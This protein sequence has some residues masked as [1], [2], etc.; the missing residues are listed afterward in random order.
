MTVKQ[1]T[2][3]TAENTDTYTSSSLARFA[4]RE[5]PFGDLGFLHVVFQSGERYVYIGVP[6]EE[7]EEL[8][9]RAYYPD[10]YT[11]SVGKFFYKNIRNKYQRKNEDYQKL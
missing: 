1:K 6:E 7:A 5:D 11:D 4:W 2:N 10:R 8:R 9:G 3:V